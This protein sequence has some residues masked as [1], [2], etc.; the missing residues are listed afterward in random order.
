MLYNV[1]ILF[2]KPIPWR[3]KE[4]YKGIWI[5][6]ILIALS[7]TIKLRVNELSQLTKP[8]GSD[9]ITFLWRYLQYRHLNSLLKCLFHYKH[10]E[11]DFDPEEVEKEAMFNQLQKVL[12]LGIE[13]FQI[14]NML[15]K[16]FKV[17][18]LSFALCIALK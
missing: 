12:R 15:S 16:N 3:V 6:L 10:L 4:V 2:L 13:C 18:I 11:Q 9:S 14:F 5:Q 8:N 7:L 1:V 17:A